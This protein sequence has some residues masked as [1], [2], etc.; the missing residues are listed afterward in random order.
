ML[1]QAN[2][3]LAG[4]ENIY[5]FGVRLF[6]TIRK[7][8]RRAEKERDRS[9][10]LA[11]TVIENV[12][13]TIIVQDAR[14]LRLVLINRAGEQFYGARREDIIGKT[15]HDRLPSAAA[16]YVTAQAKATLRSG[17]C[18]Y[19]DEHPIALRGNETRIVA[20]TRLPIRG[21]NG[22][23]QYLLT[24]IEDRTQRKRDEARIAHMAHHDPLTDLPNRAAFNECL[25]ATLKQAAWRVRASPC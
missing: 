24:V 9:R 23:P 16:D 7:E 20:T 4:S 21:Q 18:R 22:E 3:W 25:E 5:D 14:D 17:E 1:T 13:V 8:R 19:F 2:L 12:P 11:N 6:R 15:A 10:E